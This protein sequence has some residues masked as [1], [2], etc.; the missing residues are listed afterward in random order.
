MGWSIKFS[1]A[2]NMCK[3][4]IEGGI[5]LADHD[6]AKLICTCTDGSVTHWS[7]AVTQVS[8]ADFAL[9]HDQQAQHPLAF[10][11]SQFNETQLGWSTIENDSYAVLPSIERFNWIAACS[12]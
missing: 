3:H 2:F 7:G 12:G 8:F 11:S 10:H 4:A 5:K 9:P 6:S 1:E